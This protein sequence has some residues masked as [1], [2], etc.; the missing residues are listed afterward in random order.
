M[1]KC[2]PRVPNGMAAKL[3]SLPC[4]EAF[5]AIFVRTPFFIAQA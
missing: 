2:N 5:G 1:M 3:S 4:F